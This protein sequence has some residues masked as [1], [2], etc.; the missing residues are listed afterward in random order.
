MDSIFSNGKE[1]DE[2]W[3]NSTDL[4][5]GSGDNNREIEGW[6]VVGDIQKVNQLEHLGSAVQ[7]I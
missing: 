4:T 5:A 6:F 2:Y 7:L 3:V 1:D